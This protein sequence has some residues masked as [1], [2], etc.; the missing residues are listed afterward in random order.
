MWQQ[1]V[2]DFRRTGLGLKLV[3]APLQRN[4]QIFQMDIHDGRS[5]EYFRIWPGAR[6]NVVEVL[7]GDLR[8]RQVVLRV[9]EVRRRFLETLS[10]FPWQDRAWAETQAA[11]VGGRIARETPR[12]WTVE[13]WTPEEE[14]RFLCGADESRL[15]IA[16]VRHGGTVPEAHAALK[17][18][19]V[20]DAEERLLG[21]V[22][23]QGEWFFL[24]ASSTDVEQIRAHIAT[25]PR[26]L[27]REA[28]L[29]RGGTPH[30]AD[31]VVRVDRRERRG[32]REV[33]LPEVYAVG[34]VRH[35][36]HAA[37]HLERWHRVVHN[38]EVE[39]PSL[40]ERRVR[41]ID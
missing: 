36:D 4:A 5:G 23:R 7:D 8:L 40:E 32:G 34:W 30:L 26:A 2:E 39:Q 10:R 38:A 6:G 33:R 3:E 29:G 25:H 19:E 14:R 27:E 24:P 15:F 18:E 41:W 16:Q 22:R 20:V 28:S 13:R 12:Q 17:P 37:L 21:V 31:E 9:L 1:V 11:R 35:P